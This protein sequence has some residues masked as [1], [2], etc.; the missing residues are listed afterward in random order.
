M[1][2]YEIRKQINSETGKQEETLFA[3][4]ILNDEII[5]KKVVAKIRE[6][7]TIDK[8]FKML[9]LGISDSLNKDF[10]EYLSYVED[11][12]TWGNEQKIKTEQERLKWRNNFRLRNESEKEYITRI[13][14]ILQVKEIID[15]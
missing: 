9:R 4:D 5:D 8:E 10:Q 1:Y 14:P 11:C 15:K 2:K 3:E 13:K 6:K 7:Y 12:E